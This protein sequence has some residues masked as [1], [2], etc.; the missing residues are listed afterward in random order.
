MEQA[1]VECIMVTVSWNGQL[2]SFVARRPFSD[3]PHQQ[4]TCFTSGKIAVVEKKKS[5]QI[6][7][8]CSELLRGKGD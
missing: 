6:Y 5:S 3:E 1:W 2:C 4:T 8:D 7:S